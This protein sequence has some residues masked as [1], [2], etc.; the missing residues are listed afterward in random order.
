M[1]RRGEWD[2]VD[3]IQLALERLQWGTG[4]NTLL[5]ISENQTYIVDRN[6]K[7][8]KNINCSEYVGTTCN[9]KYKIPTAHILLFRIYKIIQ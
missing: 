5:I 9:S 4:V 6:F 7:H 8:K 2:C 1:E 3:S